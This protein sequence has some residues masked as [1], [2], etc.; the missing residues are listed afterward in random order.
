M[1]TLIAIELYK[2]F[3]K[4]RTYIGFAAI[5]VIVAIVQLSMYMEG[6]SYLDFIMKSLKDTFEFTGSLINGYLIANIIL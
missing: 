6:A 4:W 2:I 5:V 1:R 3:R